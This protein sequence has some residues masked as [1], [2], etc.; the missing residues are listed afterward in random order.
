MTHI[1]DDQLAELIIE[2]EQK[3]KVGAQYVHYKHSDQ[4]YTVIAVGLLEATQ[5]PCVVYRRDSKP[6]LT[7]VRLVSDWLSSVETEDGSH[8]PRFSKIEGK[9]TL[10]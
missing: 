5:E 6:K 9:G 7:W 1:S 4:S 10:L 2:A 8:V 3:V